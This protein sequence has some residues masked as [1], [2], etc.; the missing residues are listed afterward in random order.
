GNIKKDPRMAHTR[1]VIIARD[2]D[3]ARERYGDEV[4]YV[5]A[6]LTGE[7]LVTAV[8]TALAE[9][10]SAGAERGEAYAQGA[11]AALLAMA[12][13]KASID[14]ALESLA[15]Q[16]NRNDAVAVPAAK[17]IGLAGGGAQL[18]ALVGALEGAGSNDLKVAAAGA[19]G[20]ILAR[21]AGCPDAVLEALVGV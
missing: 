1:V 18:D 7:N 11:S 13:K 8:N 5:Q 19:I 12:S 17:A 21:A 20:D 9:V 4:G 16:L 15:L 14:G 2:I 10:T 3:V 6:P